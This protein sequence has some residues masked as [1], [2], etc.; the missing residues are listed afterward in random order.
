MIIG[1][2]VFHDKMKRKKSVGGFVA[3]LNKTFSSWFSKVNFH[4]NLD[5]I[6]EQMPLNVASNCLT[7]FPWSNENSYLIVL[8]SL[9]LLFVPISFATKDI[10]PRL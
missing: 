2:D 10:Q 3:S 9:Q 1:F 4:N 7:N 5:D 8:F 6:S